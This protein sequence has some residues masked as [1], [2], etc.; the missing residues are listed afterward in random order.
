MLT[1]STTNSTF[2]TLLGLYTGT[3]VAS[4]TTIADNDDAYDGAPGGF[5][6]IT[7]AVRANQIYDI[8]VDGYDGASGNISLSYSFTPATVYHLTA[9]NTAGGTVQLTTT[10]A[11]GGVWWQPGQSGDFASGSSV[12]LTALPDAGDQFNDWSGGMCFIE[13]SAGGHGSKQPE[14]DGQFRPHFLHGWI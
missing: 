13:Q 4:L 3:N 9:G 2:D 11:L 8:A 10:N 5:S 6:L 12:M 7:Q 14:S 1:L